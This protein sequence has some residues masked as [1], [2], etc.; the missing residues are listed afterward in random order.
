MNCLKKK[1]KLDYLSAVEVLQECP[2]VLWNFK[3]YREYSIL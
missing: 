2:R 1:P 3:G